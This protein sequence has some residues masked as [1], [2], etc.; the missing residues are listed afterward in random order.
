MLDVQVQCPECGEL[1]YVFPCSEC[2]A[3]VIDERLYR[4]YKVNGCTKYNTEGLCQ[5]GCNQCNYFHQA[6]LVHILRYGC[7]LRDESGNPYKFRVIEIDF[8]NIQCEGIGRFPLGTMRNRGKYPHNV[9]KAYDRNDIDWWKSN[10][11]PEKYK[12]PHG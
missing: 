11:N 8:R 12:G 3:V 4:L 5:M 1:V 2:G 9:L 6:Q 7:V 10:E